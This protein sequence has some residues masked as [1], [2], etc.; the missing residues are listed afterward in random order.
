[1]WIGLILYKSWVGNNTSYEF[2]GAA[3]LSSPTVSFFLILPLFWL[4]QLPILSSTTVPKTL[5]QGCDID[6]HLW[7]SLPQILICLN[8]NQL[9][10]VF[11]LCAK[12]LPRWR[13]ESCTNWRAQRHDYVRQFDLCV[14]PDWLKCCYACSWIYFEY[15]VEDMLCFSAIKPW[16]CFY[17]SLQPFLVVLVPFCSFCIVPLYL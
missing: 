4:L 6:I 13:Y 3:S 12:K 15:A 2:M 5:L 9:C 1:M 8:F 10:F 7:L 16:L 11:F 14:L 17:L